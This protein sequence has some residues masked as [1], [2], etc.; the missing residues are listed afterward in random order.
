M[1]KQF[2]SLFNVIFLR[3]TLVVLTL[4]LHRLSLSLS[5]DPVCEMSRCHQGDLCPFTYHISHYSTRRPDFVFPVP[6]LITFY[7]NPLPFLVQDVRSLPTGDF[8]LL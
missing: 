4:F 8:N 5:Q 7:P 1:L 3:Y 2:T 6:L